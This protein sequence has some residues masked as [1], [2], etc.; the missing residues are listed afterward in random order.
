[1]ASYFGDGSGPAGA[2]SGLDMRYVLHGG[3][4][5]IF[6]RPILAGD[7][8]TAEPGAT[9]SYEKEGKRG[10]TMPFIESEMNYR[11]QK[12][13][14]RLAWQEHADSNR[15]GGDELSTSSFD[16]VKEGEVREFTTPEFTRTHFVRYAGAGGDYNP[17]HHDQTFAEKAGLPTVFGMGLFTAGVIEPDSGGMV[18]PGE[19]SPIRR[20]VHTRLARRRRDLQG[21][22]HESL[23]TGRPQAR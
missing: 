7:I 22:R 18:Q 13:R 17:I 1:M 19:G 21:S 4:E 20:E 23:R 11:D 14:N 2:M 8:R 10:G 16:E 3:Q 9:S 12:W 15:R 6:Q 5:W